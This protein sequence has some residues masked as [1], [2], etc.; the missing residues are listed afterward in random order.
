MNLL[1]NNY[2]FV[3]AD[4]RGSY[5][6][7]GITLRFVLDYFDVILALS[8]ILILRRLYK[9]NLLQ[10]LLHLAIW[11]VL[12]DLYFQFFTRFYNLLY[13]SVRLSLSND[14]APHGCPLVA[15]FSG[16][17]ELDLEV[18]LLV[19]LGLLGT[20]IAFLTFSRAQLV[21][22]DERSIFGNRI[23]L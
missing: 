4:L 7:G 22:E 14:R 8:I 17:S 6:G 20:R 10:I 5:L 16:A 23:H 3:V 2:D 18:V 9:D 12:I 15:C 21:F 1:R 19:Y 11:G 13:F